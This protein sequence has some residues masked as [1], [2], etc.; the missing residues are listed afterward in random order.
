MAKT[1]P[2]TIVLKEVGEA[3]Y[4]EFPLAA[5]DACGNGAITP[6]ML[7]ELSAGEVQPHSTSAGLAA[8][9]MFAVE[10]LNL[11]AASLTM[12]DID[13]DYDDDG[14]AVKVWYPKQGAEAYAFLVAGGNVAAQALLE[15]NGDGY[16]KAGT[17]HPVAR[18]LE[19]KNNGA[20]SAAAR[21]KVEVIS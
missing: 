7:V 16:L 11:D 13:T 17:T 3:L 18:A 10:G 1:N 12:G 4:K 19:A 9:V 15:S 5:L 20:G 21:I 2:S 6:G 14:A 8:P